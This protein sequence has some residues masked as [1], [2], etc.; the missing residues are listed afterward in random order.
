MVLRLSVVADAV[1]VMA[2]L[3]MASL[4]MTASR[5][6]SLYNAATQNYRSKYGVLRLTISL[7]GRL[8]SSITRRFASIDRNIE[9]DITH[10]LYDPG[11]RTDSRSD[12]FKW[13][14]AATSKFVSILLG[15][16]GGTLPCPTTAVQLF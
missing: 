1:L 7:A 16:P 2:S 13:F 3:S 15:H 10:S 4:I 9:L 12:L 6:C 8:E 14:H 11:S 5:I